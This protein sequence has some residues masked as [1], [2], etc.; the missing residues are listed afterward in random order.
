MY[1]RQALVNRRSSLLFAGVVRVEGEFDEGD[2][3]VLT[4]ENGDEIGKGRSNYAAA[5]ARPFLGKRSDEIEAISGKQP[6]EFVH[7][8]YIVILV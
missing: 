3:V 6:P 4:T 2:V 1:K 5:D 8:D 7:S